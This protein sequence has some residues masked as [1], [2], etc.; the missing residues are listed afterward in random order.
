MSSWLRR[1]ILGLLGQFPLFFT[2]KSQCGNPQP[3]PQVAWLPDI[4]MMSSL[5][6]KAMRWVS[7][8][9]KVAA[10]SGM[11]PG[12]TKIGAK[13]EPNFGGLTCFDHQNGYIIWYI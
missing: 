1:F 5:K 4:T 6:Y 11:L 7:L 9:A 13:K 3:D 8:T 12:D 2:I 10:A